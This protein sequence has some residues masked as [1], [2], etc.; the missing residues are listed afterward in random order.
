E[1]EAHVLHALDPAHAVDG[2]RRVQAEAAGRARDRPEKPHLLVE[3][4][5][6]DG[7]PDHLCQLADLEK[8]LVAPAP[9]LASATRTLTGDV[10]V[11]LYGPTS[12]AIGGR[13]RSFRTAADPRE[14]DARRALPRTA[15]RGPRRAA[16]FLPR[17]V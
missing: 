12:S 13:E 4:H 10:R 9:R 15:A 11:R 5:R 3:M 7:L 2:G 14:A 8:L 1:R 6:A 16:A 17:Y